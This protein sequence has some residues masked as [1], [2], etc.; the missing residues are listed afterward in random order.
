MGS[1]PSEPRPEAPE[2]GLMASWRRFYPSKLPQASRVYAVRRG[3]EWLYIGVAQGVAK[4]V[5]AKVHP[6]QITKGLPGLSYR[7][8]ARRW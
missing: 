8:A 2:A 4:R 7:M 3:R 1:K 5:T 6:V